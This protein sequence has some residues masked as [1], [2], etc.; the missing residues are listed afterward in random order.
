MTN[1]ARPRPGRTD[2]GARQH[3]RAAG[4]AGARRGSW[5]RLR[6][7]VAVSTLGLLAEDRAAEAIRRELAELYGAALA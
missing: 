1:V 4:G 6:Y 3:D 5:A 7:L 2:A